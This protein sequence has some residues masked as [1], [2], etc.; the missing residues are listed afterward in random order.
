LIVEDSLATVSAEADVVVKLK[1]PRDFF[2][3]LD[4][5]GASIRELNL[6]DN[7]AITG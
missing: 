6:E 1:S 7:S 5:H 3:G 2:E 4:L